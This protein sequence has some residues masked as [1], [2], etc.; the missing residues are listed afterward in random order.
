MP[1]FDLYEYVGYIVPGSVLLLCLMALCPWIRK[2]FDGRTSAANNRRT[3]AANIGGTSAA[4]IGTFLIVTFLLGHFLHVVAHG[5]ENQFRLS[6]EA[7]VLGQN[8]VVTNPANQGILSEADLYDLRA[9]VS[10]QFK[11]DMENL[12]FNKTQGFVTWYNALVS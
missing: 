1:S 5:F 10:R 11:V 2:Q 6:C 9:K 7:G 4:N 12:T 8:E 3:S